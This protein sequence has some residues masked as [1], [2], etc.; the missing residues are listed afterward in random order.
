MGKTVTHL[1]VNDKKA[2]FGALFLCAFQKFEVTSARPF[3]AP[4]V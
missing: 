3:I 4:S 1:S 2:H